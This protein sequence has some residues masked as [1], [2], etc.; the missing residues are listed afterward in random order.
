[1]LQICKFVLNYT[2]HNKSSQIFEMIY[3]GFFIFTS[4]KPAFLKVLITFSLTLELLENLSL[5]IIKV[6]RQS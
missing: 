6:R 4:Q 2:G 1:M 3:H 5:L